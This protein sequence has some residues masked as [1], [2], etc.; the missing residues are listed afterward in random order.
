M[1]MML[2]GSDSTVRIEVLGEEL[3]RLREVCELTLAEVVARIGI[4]ESHLSRFEKG[5]RVPSP[6]DVSALLVIYGVTG[7][8]R[9]ELLTLAK[10]AGQPG[11]WQ[12][13]G[14]FESKFA[15]LKLL[16]S[17]ATAL[18]SFEPLMIPGLLQTMPYAEACIREVSMREE[19][20][21]IDEWVVGR[22]RRQAVLRKF[23]APPL[24]AVISEA[25]LRC[26][27]GGR[28]VLRD[29][30][31]YLVE[32]AERSNVTLRIV[33]TVVGGHP[34][35][36]GSFLRLRFADRP[37]VVFLESQTSNLFLED[38]RDVAAYDQAIVELLSVALNEEDSVRLVAEMAATLE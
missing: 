16:E 20:E 26:P 7:E 9:Y 33:P 14:S 31:R 38:H 37:S 35:L 5:K 24:V 8:E 10:K 32:A 17:R 18:M 3:R 4:S 1:T 30:L 22:I 6:E 2:S 19:Q 36:L 12:R 15:T 11:L 28:A 21:A 13:D 34:G 29:Q 23:D 25:A 27:I